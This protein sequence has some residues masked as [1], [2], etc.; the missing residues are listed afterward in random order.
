MKFRNDIGAL[1]ALAVLAVLFFHF[2]IP[3]FDG[4]FSGVDIFFVIS[5]YLMTHIILKG[6]ENNIF[7]FKQFYIKR[8][9]RIIPALVFLI[10]GTAIMGNL[11]LLPNDLQQLGNNSFFSILLFPISITTS[12]VVTLMWRH[13][14]IYCYTPGHY[15]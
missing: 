7:S 13:K 8:V 12:I 11:I 3:Y 10:V 15:L 14:I 1:R 9:V 2:K 5:G 4:G 6:F